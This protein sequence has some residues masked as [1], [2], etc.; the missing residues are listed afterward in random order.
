M[1]IDP[2]AVG[3]KGEPAEHSWSS[4][5]CLLYAVGVGAGALDP[6]DE[7]AFTSE[8]TGSVPQ[9]VLPTMAVV[10]STGGFGAMRSIGTFNPAMLVHGEQAIEL[11]QPIP[12]TGRVSTVGEITAI[13]DKGKG[14]VVETRSVSTDLAS[15]QPLFTT[16]SSAFIRGEG[17]W[18]GDRGPSGSRN[19]APDREPDQQVTY[20]T[21]TDQALLYRLSGDLHRCTPTLP[22]RPWA[23]STS[24]SSTGCTYGFTGR[25]LL[26]TLCSSDP[27]RFRS[28]EGRFSSPVFPGESLTVKMWATGDSEATFQTSG[29]EAASSSTP[30]GAPSTELVDSLRLT[31]TLFISI[32]GLNVSAVGLAVVASGVD[33]AV[34]RVAQHRLRDGDLVGTI[35]QDP[36]HRRALA[37]VALA[38]C[39]KVAGQ[40][41]AVN[42][43]TSQEVTFEIS[44]SSGNAGQSPSGTVTVDGL[45]DPVTCLAVAGTRA[46][47]VYEDQHFGV[48]FFVLY[49]EDAGA[50]SSGRDL[51]K[52]EVWT[53]GSTSCT[54]PTASQFD[55]SSF[56]VISGG[57]VVTD[58]DV[59]AE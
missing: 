56:V 42:P 59:A 22:S 5:D 9:Q 11:H 36:S 24:R 8:N 21:R 15:G 7:L 28:M 34:L 48:G 53:G 40:G 43:F 57:I 18:G 31:R 12:V 4:K 37:L 26:H 17:G 35:D 54:A 52:G 33:G 20:A 14:A 16:V 10:L 1:P 44:A 58:D 2:N 27:G 45:T 3:T 51:V 30:D 39:D 55:Q 6:L 19:Q 25:A 46:S 29:D 32:A 41:R 47:I 23:A 38:G 50:A 49:V 13:W